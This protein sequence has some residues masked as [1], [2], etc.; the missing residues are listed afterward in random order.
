MPAMSV[1]FPIAADAQAALQH[2]LGRAERERPARA[3]AGG[4]VRFVRELVGP[5]FATREAAEAAYAGKVDTAGAGAVAPEDR[6]CDLLEVAVPAAR[7][8]QAEPVF[9]AG[10]RW[11][12]P[13]SQL[14]TAFRLSI[15]YWRTGGEAAAPETQQARTARKAADAQALDPSTLQAMSRQPLKPVKPQQPLD[16]GLFEVRP[17]EAPHI[18]MPD[19]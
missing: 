11:P 18:I 14:K 16:I 6:Y 2:P 1:R 17:P 13:K 12:R 10:R 7:G 19:E 4:D 3:L 5:S 9:E 15:G 8:G